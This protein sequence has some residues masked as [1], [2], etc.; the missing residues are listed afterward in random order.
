MAKKKETDPV[1]DFGADGFDLIDG[2]VFKFPGLYENLVDFEEE[3]SRVARRVGELHDA[4]E[5]QRKRL[6]EYPRDPREAVI[7]GVQTRMQHFDLLEL[8]ASCHEAVAELANKLER[9]SADI[10]AEYAAETRQLRQEVTAQLE[11]LGAGG[12]FARQACR[13]NKELQALVRREQ[14]ADRFASVYRTCA[15]RHRVDLG[16]CQN[17]LEAAAKEIAHGSIHAAIVSATEAADYLRKYNGREY[18]P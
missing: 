8:E 6:S 10:Q 11:S 18:T 15:H 14:R 9:A 16:W 2:R 13:E 5:R 1:P 7:F 4:T 3:H 17:A 12:H